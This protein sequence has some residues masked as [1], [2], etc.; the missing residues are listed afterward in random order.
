MLLTTFADSGLSDSQWWEPGLIFFIL[1]WP[2]IVTL[3]I[4]MFIG[5]KLGKKSVRKSKVINHKTIN[6][7]KK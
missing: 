2:V 1:I 7:E 4:G 6:Q 3:L 5:Y